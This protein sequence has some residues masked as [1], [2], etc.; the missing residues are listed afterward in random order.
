MQQPRE[1]KVGLGRLVVGLGV[2]M[3]MMRGKTGLLRMLMV[4]NLNSPIQGYGPWVHRMSRFEGQ[5]DGMR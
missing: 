2:R 4:R 3:E 1:R 5:N